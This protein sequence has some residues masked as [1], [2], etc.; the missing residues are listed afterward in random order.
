[1][2]KDGFPLVTEEAH[3]SPW[4]LPLLGILILSLTVAWAALSLSGDEPKPGSVTV[5]IAPSEPAE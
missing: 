2:G 4:W 5:K 3:E 1:M